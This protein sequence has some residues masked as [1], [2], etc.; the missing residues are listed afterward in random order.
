MSSVL[1]VHGAATTPAIWDEVRAELRDVDVSAPERPGTGDLD[2]EAT[3]LESIA[4]GAV[5]L[6]IS[7]GATLVLELAARGSRAR[8]LIA[9]EPAAGS[10]MPGFFAP[11]AAAFE[12]GG[13]A[14]FAHTLYGAEWTLAPGVTPDGVAKDLAMFRSFEPRAP[15]SPALVVTG[16]RSPAVRHELAARL[17]DSLGYPTATLDDAS[18]FACRDNPVGLAALVREALRT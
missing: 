4:D 15:R 13:V 14:G 16:E 5:V 1:L 2:A 3:W 12:T 10:L 9:Y 11:L 8:S 7:G 17:H 18:H 6:G